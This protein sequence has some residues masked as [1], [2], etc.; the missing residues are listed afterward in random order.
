MGP[1]DYAFVTQGGEDFRRDRLSASQVND[2]DGTAVTINKAMVH[3][4]KNGWVIKKTKTTNSTRT[5]SVPQFVADAIPT[6]K[7]K[8]RVVP[9]TPDY[10]TTR[11]AKY[12]KAAGVTPFR[13]HDL[14]HFG[15]SMLLTVMSRRYV[16]DRG[17][18]SSPFTMERVYNNVIDAE[19]TRQ[20]KRALKVFNGFG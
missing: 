18:W 12:V 11:F 7:P 5:V 2:I 17:G 1:F 20:T 4:P 3:T 14:R 8:D 10:V 19:K 9:L 15:A 16:Q 6:G 13:F